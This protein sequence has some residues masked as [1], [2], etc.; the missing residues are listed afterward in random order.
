[1][2]QDQENHRMRELQLEKI[3]DQMR[4]KEKGNQKKKKEEEE[5]DH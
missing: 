5:E 3:R 2:A 4:V 1:M